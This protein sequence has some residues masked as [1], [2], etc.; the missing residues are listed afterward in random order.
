MTPDIIHDVT[1]KRLPVLAVVLGVLGLIPFLGCTIGI[2][3]FPSDVPA[4]NLVRAIIAYGAVIL[5]FLG[6]VHWGL[7]LDP[8]PTMVAPGQAAIDNRRL[9]LGVLPSLIGWAALLVSVAS[10]SLIAIVLL[11]LGF[12]GTT[13][14]EQRAHRSGALPG[15]YMALRWVLSAVALLCLVVVLLAR[16]F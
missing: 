5:A 8:A 14:V 7:A 13:L 3:L 1:K 15:S 12:V 9:A 4:P 6:G 10:T 16:T 2:I 11:I